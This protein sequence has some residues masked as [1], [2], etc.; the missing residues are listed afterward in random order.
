MLN[1]SMSEQ[2]FSNGSYFYDYTSLSEYIDTP[3]LII[4]GEYDFAIG[5]DHYRSFKFK[6]SIV[7]NIK[8]VHNPYIENPIELEAIIKDFIISL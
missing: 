5:P 1:T 7:R 8:G 2:S 4:S 3:T 6:N